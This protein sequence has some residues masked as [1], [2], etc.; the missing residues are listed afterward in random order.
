MRVTLT[1]E[2]KMTEP[3]TATTLATFEGL[4]K[5]N[6]DLRQ[7]SLTLSDE[8]ARFLVD[9]YYIVQE[10]RKRTFNQT[11][12]LTENQ[13]PNQLVIWVGETMFALE[14]SIKYSL[15]KYAQTKK[16]GRWCLSQ[17]G[18]G[19]VITA[20]ILANVD[21]HQAPTVGHIWR[22]AGL[23][24][25]L[26]WLGKEKSRKLVEEVM[27]KGK[28]VEEKHIVQIGIEVNRKPERIRA[29]AEDPET[30]KM[31]RT[32]LIN[33]LARRPYNV[34]L[35]T[36]C[37]F[38]MGECFVKTCNHDNAFY[39]RVYAD[40]K[41]MEWERNISGELSDQAKE[42][43]ARFNIAKTTDAYKWYSGSITDEQARYYLTTGTLPPAIETEGEKVQMLPPAHIHAR[44]RRYAVKMFLSH[45]HYV[46]FKEEFKKEPPVPY[47]LQ[48]EKGHTHFI[49]PPNWPCE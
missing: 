2:T 30:K 7:A 21:I 3:M 20:G 14:K 28:K 36:L 6:K 9:L 32:S 34:T 1:K 24:P 13:E 10:D 18:V 35:K 5:L 38:K 47:M 23:D 37:A 27:G 4:G 19:P 39:G 17:V 26:D 48:P 12:A 31:T 49:A 16:I 8:E 40:R 46:W 29:L 33:A 22:F 25:T 42:K 43:L 45:L 11:R 44:A 41:A 15:G